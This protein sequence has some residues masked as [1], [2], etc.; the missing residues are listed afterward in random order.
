MTNE[1]SPDQDLQNVGQRLA[2]L[3]V[4][5][6]LPDEV[7]KSVAAMVPEMSLP[8]MDQL[9]GIL[10]RLVSDGSNAELESFRAGLQSIQ[11][12]FDAEE[13]AIKKKASDQLD[14]IKNHIP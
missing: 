11:Q 1:P 3:L 9:A 7:K 13:Q 14:A 10:E 6:D 2:L 12:G 8:Q 4:A 5:S